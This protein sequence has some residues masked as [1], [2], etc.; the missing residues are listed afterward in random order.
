M[1]DRKRTEHPS[2][3]FMKGMLQEAGEAIF[4]AKSQTEETLC[5]A[6]GESD[7]CRF[8]ISFQ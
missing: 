7:V 2:C 1:A 6:T 8:E 4:G 3:F 5:R